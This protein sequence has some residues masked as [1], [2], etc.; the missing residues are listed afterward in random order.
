MAI[1]GEMFVRD[2]TNIRTPRRIFINDG[3]VVREATRIYV[4][5]QGPNES[6]DTITATDTWDTLSE[7]T[8]DAFP[9]G[10]VLAYSNS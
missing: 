10:I 6:W 5:E 3:G 8:W 9:G 7:A 4:R 2:G 1:P